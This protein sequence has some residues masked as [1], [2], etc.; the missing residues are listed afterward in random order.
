MN[1]VWANRLR[2]RVRTTENGGRQAAFTLIELLV[3]IAIIGI[4]ITL[5]IPA[6]AAARNQASRIKCMT[7]ER[8]LI[9]ALIMYSEDIQSLPP[10]YEDVGVNKWYGSKYLGKYFEQDLDELGLRHPRSPLFCPG[11]P[12]FASL[13][14]CLIGYN[15]NFQK[16]HI[17]G[18]RLPGPPIQKFKVNPGTVVAFVDAQG[19]GFWY[20]SQWTRQYT[21]PGKP[22]NFAFV[23]DPPKYDPR[24]D[25]DATGGA[26]YAFC[27]GTVR[28]IRNSDEL[29]RAGG[30]TYDGE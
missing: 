6:L 9:T 16:G 4:L 29:Y 27:D 5:L 26:N 28:Y 11:P 7:N 17:T 30:F 20:A 14:S 13:K 10:Y 2:E 19:N 15:A 12:L 8:F 24:H 21:P 25:G 18:P 23:G 22:Q 3:V 1:L